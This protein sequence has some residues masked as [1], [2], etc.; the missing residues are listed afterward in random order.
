MHQSA[1]KTTCI[2]FYCCHQ[3]SS[4]LSGY[5][6][7][8]SEGVLWSWQWNTKSE[9]FRSCFRAISSTQCSV[10]FHGCSVGLKPVEC[11]QFVSDYHLKTATSKTH[12]CKNGI[13]SNYHCA[14]SK[15]Q[16]WCVLHNHMEQTYA[17]VLTVKFTAEEI[18]HHK[19]NNM[20]VYSRFFIYILRQSL[21]CRS[22]PTKAENPYHPLKM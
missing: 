22:V 21:V 18:G 3:R 19:N 14:Q 6:L 1:F 7:E 8:N 5:G 2:I 15:M 10:K 17:E 9:S 11:F 12:T 4:D 16:N 13:Y 20:P